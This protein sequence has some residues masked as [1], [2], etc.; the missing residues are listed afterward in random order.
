MTNYRILL[1]LIALFAFMISCNDDEIFIIDGTDFPVKITEVLTSA[2]ITVNPAGVSPLTAMIDMVLLSEWAIT[3]MTMRVIGVDG[4][5]SDVIRM[6]ELDDT[7]KEIMILGLYGGFNNSVELTFYNANG[8]PK[9]DTILRIQTVP[10]S[11]DLPQIDINVAATADWGENMHLVSY[12]GSGD[13]DFFPQSPFIMDKFGKIRWYLNYNG[14][15]V[16]NDYNYSN[17]MSR[18]KNGNFMFATGNVF[19]ALGGNAVYEVDMLG[20]LV[21]SWQMGD[22]ANHHQA[23][24]L[25]NGNF[26]VDVHDL[27]AETVEDLIIEID[28]TSGAIVNMMDL[29]ESLN[30][31]RQV[32]N[33]ADESDWIH[34][35][36]LSI[37]ESDGNILVSGRTQGVIK[38]THNNEV[39][40]ILGLHNEWGMSGNGTELDQYLLT[41]LDANDQPITDTIFTY[42]DSTH[43]D[44]EFPWFQHAVKNTPSGNYSMFDNGT[45]RNF[46]VDAEGNYSRA[47]EYEIDEVNMTVKQVWEYGRERETETFSRFVSD[48]DYRDDEGSVIFSPGGVQHGGATYGKVVEVDYPSGN[49]IF[50]ATIN[51]PNCFFGVVCLHRSE[52]LSLYP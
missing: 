27:N 28:R 15:A 30:Q 43:A 34:V 35:N 7:T 50:E 51:A 11:D 44:F 3:D 45:S 18:L 29:K 17:G 33:Q 47:V 6:Y 41:P 5:E 25:E 19:G 52:R 40:W 20:N 10:N 39:V 8:F 38:L 24:E 36:S 12:W 23:L 21:N 14:H 4:S 22:L 42:G 49:V 46:E 16:L 2:T 48:V 32:L 31:F 37:D 9:A 26:L 1:P 13:L